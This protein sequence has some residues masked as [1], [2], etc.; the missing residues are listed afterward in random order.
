[1]TNNPNYLD[2]DQK[3]SEQ[4]DAYGRIKGAKTETGADIY[5]GLTNAHMSFDGIKCLEAVNGNIVIRGRNGMRDHIIK[6]EKALERYFNWMDLVTNYCK[7][8]VQ[9]WQTA[10]DIAVDFKAK[11]CEA[12]EQ[13]MQA[14]EQVPAA[15]LEFY[16]RATAAKKPT[17][18]V[19]GTNE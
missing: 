2:I 13:R 11:I 4:E 9:G 16:E 12:V 15:A 18:V 3:P 14:Q 10:F 8:G 19:P 7:L 6:L 17:V 1:M 5:A